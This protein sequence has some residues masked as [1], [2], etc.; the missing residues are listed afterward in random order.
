MKMKRALMYL[1]IALAIPLSAGYGQRIVQVPAG[2]GTIQSVILGDTTSTGARVDTNTV[3]VLHTDSLYILDGSFEPTFQVIMESDGKPGAMPHIILGVPS[4]GT[5]PDQAIRPHANFYAKGI[6]F[7]AEAELNSGEGTRVFRFQENGIKISLDSCIIS[8]ASQ[9]GFRLDTENDVLVVKKCIIRDIGVVNGTGNGRAFDTRGNHVDSLIVTN[10]T[11]YNLASR[12]VRQGGGS[13]DYVYFDHNTVD[14]LGQGGFDLT[15]I[16]YLYFASN[17]IR[18]PE[19]LG[20]TDSTSSIIQY[21]ME[22][23]ASTPPIFRNNNIFT[24][25]ALVNAFPK[26]STLTIYLPLNFDSTSSYY[27]RASGDSATNIDEL[28]NFT[29]GPKSPV[30]VMLNYYSSSSST[31]LPL[32]TVDEANFDF[33]YSHGYKSYSAALEGKPLGSLVWFGLPTAIQSNRLQQPVGYELSQNYPNPFNPTTRI[34]YSVPKSGYVSLKVYNV[35]GE[36]VASL[37]S[38]YLTAGVHEA[39]F[40][41]RN[42]ASG[43]YFYMLRAGDYSVARKMVL[44]K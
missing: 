15:Q 28:V 25:T 22:D 5:V 17:I 11:I 39:V 13:I 4:G 1:S 34:E 14:N 41:G 20:N 29:K 35:L 2:F 42:L 44:L 24:D 18:N 37:A 19:F 30:D 43:V 7:S 3:Y 6:W 36:L 8:D 21:S 12:V 32:D 31:P 10:C 16:G 40:D 9:A 27:I 23:S 26:T 38:G 33:S